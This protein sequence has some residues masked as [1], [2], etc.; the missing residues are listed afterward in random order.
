MSRVLGRRG[1]AVGAGVA[2]LLSL[3]LAGCSAGTYDAYSG[4]VSNGDVV[5]DWTSDC[6][7]SLVMTAGGKVTA[8][9]FPTAWDDSGNATKTFSGAGDWWLSNAPGGDQGLSVSLNNLINILPYA[10]VH[11]KLGFAYDIMYDDAAGEEF[12]IFSK[13]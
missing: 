12:C 10:S 3:S 1:A 4:T 5:G 11:G 2:A 13:A 7:A 8:T 6:A 9:A